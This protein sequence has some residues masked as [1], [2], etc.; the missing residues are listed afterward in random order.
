[1]TGVPAPT[2]LA[3]RRAGPADSGAL[4]ELFARVTMDADLVLSVDR[5]PDFD[6]L[7]RLHADDW[8]CWV[9]ERDGEL[10]GMGTVLV[11]D[12][13]IGGRPAKVGYLG[14][15]RIAPGL[16][17][18]G[19]LGRFYGPALQAAATGTGAQ[20]FL[21]AVIASNTKAIAALT[22]AGAAARGIPPYTLLRRFSIRAVH[23]TV[24]RRPR[25]TGYTVRRATPADIPALAAL[26]DRDG[27][28]RPYG[29][30]LDE[31]ELR[32]RLATWPGLSVGDFLLA[33]D[34]GGDLAGCV[35]AWDADAVK[36][37]VVTGYR[38]RMRAVRVAYNTAA[39]VLRFPPLP[40]PGGT[41]A[42]RYLTHQAVPSGDPAVLAA[43][44]DVAYA[45]LRRSGRAF[46][47][48]C[49]WDGD[50]LAAAYT[51]FVRTDLPAHLYAVTLPGARVPAPCVADA[52]PGFEMALV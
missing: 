8:T 7:Y 25:R 17:G 5:R 37:T 28:A 36:R 49:V 3:L 43:L 30:A 42:Y 24:P 44:L 33:A 12:G 45:D 20:V 14:D 1:M 22:G 4:C 11:R 47:S 13:Y 41:L 18:G 6:A 51:G 23:A 48:A 31:A 46:L 2:D 40:A 21:T 19:L 27:R 34:R 38:G 29:Y 9:G 10:Q 15:L 52:P 39:A 26:L 50:P 32:R 35:A 16:Q